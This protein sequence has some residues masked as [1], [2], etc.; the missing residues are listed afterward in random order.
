MVHLLVLLVINLIKQLLPVV[1]KVVEELLMVDHLSLTVEKHGGGL[2][3]VLTSVKP[4]AHAVV[5][6]TLTSVLEHVDTVH[7]ERLGCLEQDLLGVEEGFSHPLDLFIV[8]MINLTTMVKHVTDV[9]YCE[10]ELVES[11]GG[12]LV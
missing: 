10:T 8:M 7:D 4:L 5:V 3:K 1:V 11:L 9:R 2:A 6:E 12:L